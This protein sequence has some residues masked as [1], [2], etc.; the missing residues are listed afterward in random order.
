M[1]DKVLLELDKEIERLKKDKQ[2][3]ADKIEKVAQA[4]SLIRTASSGRTNSTPGRKPGGKMAP[5]GQNLQRVVEAFAKRGQATVKEVMADTG[6]EI[7]AVRHAI[8]ALVAQDEPQVKETD[9]RLS[10]GEKVWA[11]LGE[12]LAAEPQAQEEVPQPTTGNGDT[13][14]V[15]EKENSEQVVNVF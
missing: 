1:N 15:Q 2:D 4:R 3:I 9:T 8:N 11:Y 5:R 14:Q 10:S 12:A 6:L 13:Q 7:Y